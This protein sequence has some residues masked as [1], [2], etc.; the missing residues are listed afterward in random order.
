[1]A[2]QHSL[3]SHNEDRSIKWFDKFDKQAIKEAIVEHLTTN[4]TD[5]LEHCKEFSKSD[6]RRFV[7]NEIINFYSVNPKNKKISLVITKGNKEYFKALK[8]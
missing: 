5:T 7:G 2:L 8:I 6:L 1:M 4:P 3:F